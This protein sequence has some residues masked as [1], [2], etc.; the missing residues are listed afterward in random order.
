M[1]SSLAQE[2]KQISDFQAELVQM[3]ACLKGDHKKKTYP[4][5][6]VEKMTVKEAV[7]YV[8]DAWKKFLH[9]CDES[10]KRG[11]DESTIVIVTSPKN[12]RRSFKGKLLSCLACNN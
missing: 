11:E 6:L 8:Q 3:A 2:N 1:R 4:Y 10:R 5:E 7:E 12:S 9:E